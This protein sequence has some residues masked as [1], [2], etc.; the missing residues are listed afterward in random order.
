MRRR[1]RNSGTAIDATNRWD[2]KSLDVRGEAPLPAPAE[3]IARLG[4]YCRRLI[5]MYGSTPE[6]RKDLHG[7]VYCIVHDL[8]EA[9]DTSR[10]VPL[11]AYLFRNLRAGVFTAARKEWR[12]YEREEPTSPLDSDWWETRKPTTE[13]CQDRVI[14]REALLQAMEQLTERQRAVVFMR[15]FQG[16][17]FDSIARQLDIEPVT[18]RSLLRNGISRLRK[19]MVDDLAPSPV[20]YTEEWTRQRSAVSDRIVTH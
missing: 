18:A 19:T 7:E 12:R 4:P 1:A 14:Q 9:Y 17:E 13:S 15:Y 8:L 10:G 3:V 5:R 11:S 20:T 6:L 16:R 2:L